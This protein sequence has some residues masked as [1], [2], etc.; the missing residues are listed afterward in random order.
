MRSPEKSGLCHFRGSTWIHEEA[1][2]DLGEEETDETVMTTVGGKLGFAI[3]PRVLV[4]RCLGRPLLRR[5][6]LPHDGDPIMGEQHEA[7]G[8]EMPLVVRVDVMG[9][10]HEVRLPPARTGL[11]R[12]G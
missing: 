2:G 1:V 8:P 5:V 11:P 10:N 3:P 9:E 4:C 7:E 6:V 12:F